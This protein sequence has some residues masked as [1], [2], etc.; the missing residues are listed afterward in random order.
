MELE[1]EVIEPSMS[2][3]ILFVSALFLVSS[4]S[5]IFPSLAFLKP[6]KRKFFSR[7]WF[8]IIGYRYFV[9]CDID[10]SGGIYIIASCSLSWIPFVFRYIHLCIFYLMNT[11]ELVP[12]SEQLVTYRPSTQHDCDVPRGTEKLF[13]ATF[14]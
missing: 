11:D 13:P 8:S 14:S 10:M 9:M 5:L 12:I 2:F 6:E 3:S 7:G 1:I 4:I